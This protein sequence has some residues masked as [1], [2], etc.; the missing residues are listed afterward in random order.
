MLGINFVSQDANSSN[1]D[2]TEVNSCARLVEHGTNKHSWVF[3][4]KHTST[5]QKMFWDFS[6]YDKWTITRLISTKA[7]CY[8]LPQEK[9]FPRKLNKIRSW[10]FYRKSSFTRFCKQF[11]NIFRT[12]QKSKNFLEQLSD[13]TEFNWNSEVLRYDK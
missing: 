13:K 3:I 6:I 5:S 12:T 7:Q 11:S 9:Q 2:K 10:T 4:N 8:E 1:I